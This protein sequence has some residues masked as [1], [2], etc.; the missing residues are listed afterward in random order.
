MPLIEVQG[1]VDRIVWEG[2]AVRFWEQYIGFNGDTKNRIWTAWFD[3]PMNVSEGDQVVIKGDL[4]TKV[5]E[6]M[7]KDATEPRSIVE[8]SLNNCQ[9]VSV[10]P[11]QPKTAPQASQAV[12][13]DAPF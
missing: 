6:W 1:Q 3:A 9:L 4:T 10:S 8:H 12:P 13:E 7:P 11:G 2:K 5:G